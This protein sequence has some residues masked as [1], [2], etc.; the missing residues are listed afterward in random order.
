MEPDAPP[1]ADDAD[2]P[3]A[4]R[5]DW[6]LLRQLRDRV[7]AAAAEIERLRSENAALAERVAGL[8]EEDDASPS[9]SFGGGG[10]DPAAL[11]A[12]VQGFIDTLDG[13]LGEARSGGDGAPAPSDDA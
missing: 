3:E 9:F 6:R 11:R 7:E 10:E 12:K 2:R 13:L 8:R 5:S 4:G 1:P